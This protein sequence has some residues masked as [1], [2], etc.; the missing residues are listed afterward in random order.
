MA[1]GNL[2]DAQ[3]TA[4]LT[5]ASQVVGTFYHDV[6]TRFPTKKPSELGMTDLFTKEIGCHLLHGQA[7][8]SKG[9]SLWFQSFTSAIDDDTDMK[10]N[11]HGADFILSFGRAHGAGGQTKTQYQIYIQA[12]KVKVVNGQEE[13]DFYYQ[14]VH[15]KIMGSEAD[16]NSFS[17]R[18]TLNGQSHSQAGLLE[19]SSNGLQANGSVN[20]GFY[21]VYKDNGVCIIPIRPLRQQMNLN[22]QNNRTVWAWANATYQHPAVNFLAG[23]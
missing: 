13:V 20:A 16:L 22:N 17:L 4:V 15:S 14:Y 2:T 6:V 5:N 8:H 11:E 12:K 3:I 1:A 9:Y 18:S 21:V 23:L 19:G 10:E 7:F